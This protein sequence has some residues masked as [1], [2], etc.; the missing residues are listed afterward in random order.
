[1]PR[2]IVLFG[3]VF[4][5][6]ACGERAAAPEAGALPVTAEHPEIDLRRV[7]AE[8]LLAELKTVG[9][10]LV[11]VNYWATWCL[12]CREEFPDL[13][14]FSNEADPERVQVRFVSVDFEDE[15]P[16]VLAFLSDYGVTGTAYLKDGSDGPFINAL[17]PQWS[18]SIPASF[19]YDREGNR[20]DFWEGKVDYDELAA[21][22][23]AVKG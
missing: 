17:N 16:A 6:S 4:L 5:L 23:E 14:R 11:V 3:L 19:I 22:V 2:L 15:A 21:R 7:T 8:E 18:G 13:M 9:S 12:P 1:M 20:L 10:D